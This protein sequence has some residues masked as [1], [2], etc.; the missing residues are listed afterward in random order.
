MP[1]EPQ[2]AFQELGKI[3]FDAMDLEGVLG[4]IAGLAKQTLPCAADVSVT[5]VRDQQ[6]HTAAFSGEL[7]LQLDETQYAH[8]FGP[9]LD[10][11][12]AA[13]TIYVADMSV[14][15][16]WPEFTRR[17]LSRG[18]KSSLS[19]SL[20]VQQAVV[21]ALNIYATDANC[22]E[23]DA[24]EMARTFASYAAVAIASAHLYETNATLAENM[25]QAMETRSVIEQAKGI[26]MAQQH[27]DAPRAFEILTKQS[28]HSNR[29]LRT[30]ATEVVR[31]ISATKP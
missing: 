24:I 22:F 17:A 14:E 16:R 8:G 15:T 13:G 7:A 21:G 29:K 26:I 18:V 1:I 6:A 4:M 23:D 31:K 30:V 19:L 27:C 28:Q 12:Q 3:Q 10:V 2:V 5:L 20:P 11:A 25:R 9:C